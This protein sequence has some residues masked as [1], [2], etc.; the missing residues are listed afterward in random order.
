MKKPH[1]ISKVDWEE[2]D[3]PPLTD[4]TLAKMV[5]V[6]ETHPQ[7]PSRVRGAQ[8]APKKVPVSIRLSPQVIEFF[9]AK[10]RKWQTRIDEALLEY[11]KSH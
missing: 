10:G 4:D 6:K 11:M 1:H 9:K 3:S 7:I 2:L 8:I 5:P